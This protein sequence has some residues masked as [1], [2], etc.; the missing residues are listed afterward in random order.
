MCVALSRTT[1]SFCNAGNVT[2]GLDSCLIILLRVIEPISW[3][4]RAREECNP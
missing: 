3:E 1:N 4:A 2:E